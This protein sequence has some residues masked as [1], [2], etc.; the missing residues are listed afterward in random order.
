MHETTSSGLEKVFQKLMVRVLVL[1]LGLF[2]F[3]FMY[4]VF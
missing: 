4:L 3:L 1:V 2:L